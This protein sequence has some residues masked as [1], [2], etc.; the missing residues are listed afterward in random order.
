MKLAICAAEATL[1]QTSPNPP[2][3]AVVVKDGKVV[4]VGCHVQAGEPHAEVHAIQMAGEHAKDATIYVTLEPCSHFGKTPPCADLII[5]KGIKRVVVGSVDENPTVSGN[6]IKKLREAGISV[7]VGVCKEETDALYQ[8][9]FTYMR[10]KR[11]LITIKA[12]LSLDGKLCTVSGDS[13]WITGEVARR[14]VH[15]ERE[16]YDCILVGI[17]TIL[18]DNPSLTV[19]LG[20]ET[21][22]PVRIVLDSHL[23]TPL[24]S[25]VMD[26]HDGKTILFVGSTVKEEQKQPYLHKGVEVIAT[27]Q[28]KV[29]IHEVMEILGKKGYHSVYVEGGSTI[30][31]ELIKENLFDNLILYYAPKIIG[32]VHNG[33]FVNE[34]AYS[35]MKDVQQLEI[36]SVEKV[37]EDIRLQV[38]KKR[39]EETGVHRNH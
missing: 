25:K 35:F 27:S 37:G 11:P 34:F 26:T 22:Q 4:G 1:G 29:S 21:K 3:G 2:V 5:K 6:G 7:E 24:D 12:A 17:G 38:R 13:K 18:K 39:K 8:S 23:R 32:G 30:H 10:N 31:S 19:R 9:F 15:E 14:R 33:V 16:K 20:Q 28:Q 36:E